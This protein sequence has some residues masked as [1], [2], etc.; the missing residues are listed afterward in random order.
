MTEVLLIEDNPGDA[1]LVQ[2]MLFEVEGAPFHLQHAE[3]LLGGLDKLADFP[4]DVILLDLNLPDS[5]GLETFTTMKSHAPATP[6][7]L[8]TGH[9]SEALALA[10]VEA[11]AQD[12]LSK[13]KLDADSLA[14]ALRYAIIRHQSGIEV[15]PDTDSGGGKTLAVVGAKGGVGATTVACHLAAELRGQTGGSV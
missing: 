12:Y 15:S 11:G 13:D 5:S 9:D 14:R 4:A 8:L 10:A 6:I 3:S 1:I 2:E 7:V